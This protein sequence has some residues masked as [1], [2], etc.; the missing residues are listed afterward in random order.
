MNLLKK[1]WRQLRYWFWTKPVSKPDPPKAIDVVNEYIVIDYKGQ[2]INLRKTE[3][4]MFDKLS[5]KDKRAMAT[6]FKVMEKKGQIRFEEINGKTVAIKNK[7]Y[8]EQAHIRQ[9]RLSKTRQG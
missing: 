9:L 1:I 8:A 7:D 5:R 3:L 2:Y 4:L 6:K